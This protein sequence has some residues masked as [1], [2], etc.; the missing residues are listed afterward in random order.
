MGEKIRFREYARGKHYNTIRALI[1]G[2]CCV[3]E[4]VSPNLFDSNFKSIGSRKFRL[5]REQLNFHLVELE[6]VIFLR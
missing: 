4:L 1:Q 5:D 3:P 2:L 6:R